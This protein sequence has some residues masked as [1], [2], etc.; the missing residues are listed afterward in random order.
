MVHWRDMVEELGADRGAVA[1]VAQELTGAA[2][3]RQA[4]KEGGGVVCWGAALG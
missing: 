4:R 1:T 2:M 3:T